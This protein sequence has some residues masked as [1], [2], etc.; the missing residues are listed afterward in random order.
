[1]EDSVFSLRDALKSTIASA[2]CHCEPGDPTCADW[3]DRQARLNAITTAVQ[4]FINRH[5]LNVNPSFSGP[6]PQVGDVEEVTTKPNWAKQLEIKS[7]MDLRTQCL[8]YAIATSQRSGREEVLKTAKRY[9]EYL[10]HGA[11][12]DT[13]QLEY[14]AVN[15]L[16]RIGVEPDVIRMMV[17]V[18]RAFSQYPHSGGS[19]E[20]C[21]PLLTKLLSFQ[22]LSPLTDDPGEWMAIEDEVVNDPEKN[23]QYTVDVCW[24]SRRNPE[25]FSTDGGKTH[26]I[27]SETVDGVRTIHQTEPWKPRSN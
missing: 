6:G 19:A 22:P 9:E 8:G 25:A 26:Y 27:L 12:E 1:M 16:Q 10:M 18:I 3:S 5:E 17:D 15:E 11:P 24:Q 14:F 20:A 21:I 7:K 13:S 4:N 23:I 2:D